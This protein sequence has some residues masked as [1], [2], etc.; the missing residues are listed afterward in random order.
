MKVQLVGDHEKDDPPAYRHAVCDAVYDSVIF[1]AD[2]KLMH[3]RQIIHT[4]HFMRMQLV[5][6]LL[7]SCVHRIHQFLV[8]VR[9]NYELIFLF[10]S[11][12]KL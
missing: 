5:M 10:S 6:K 8:Q 7:L 9:L 4:Q 12:T 3:S 11:S 2:K 1:L